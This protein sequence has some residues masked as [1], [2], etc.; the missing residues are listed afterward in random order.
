MMDVD[1]ALGQENLKTTLIA[2]Q[3]ATLFSRPP[4]RW[5]TR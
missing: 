5:R 4:N 2:D 3:G 1:D